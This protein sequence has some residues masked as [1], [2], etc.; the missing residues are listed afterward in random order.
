MED[1]ANASIQ[2]NFDLDNSFLTIKVK[3][4]MYLGEEA[5]ALYIEFASLKIYSKLENLHNR[6]KI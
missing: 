4:Q 3:K 1:I 2:E 5:I 6:E